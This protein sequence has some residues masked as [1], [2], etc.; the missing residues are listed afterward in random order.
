LIPTGSERVSRV[1]AAPEGS[2]V[3]L[4]VDS[5]GNERHQLFRYDGSDDGSGPP[6]QPLTDRPSVIHAAGGW[7]DGHRFVYASNERDQRYFDVYEL[8]VRSPGH[9][10][11]VYE[12][13]ALVHVGAVRRDRLIVVRSKSN[14]DADLLEVGGDRT[15]NLTP[16]VGEL[17]V[18]SVDLARDG[19]LAAANPDR[20]LTALVRYRAP[21]SS[22]VLREYP[23]DVEIVRVTADG[24]RAAVTVNREGWSELHVVD[25][26]ANEDRTIPLEIPG[27]I[28]S[29]E[30]T[31]DGT[32]LVFALSSTMLGQDLY[33]WVESTRR[34]EPLTRNPGPLPEVLPE[35]RLCSFTASDELTIPY[36]DL[37]PRREPPRGTVVIVHGGPEAQ[38]RPR[39]A[40]AYSFLRQEGWRI[41]LPNVRGSLGYGRTYVHLDDVRRRMDSVR[42][43]RDLVH[44]LAALGEVEPGRVG[45]LGGSYGGFMV[46]SAIATYPDLWGAAV[47]IVGISNFVTFLER[48]G[49]WRRKVREVEYGSLERDREFLESISPIGHTGAMRTPLLVIHGA[50]DPRV[51]VH[52]AEQ[53]VA[54]LSER[55]VPV[56][57]LRYDDEG[58]G[59]VRKENR[60]EA[61]ERAAAFFAKYL[62]PDSEA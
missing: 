28:E 23:G 39:F 43:L 55:K 27:V 46:L 35:A 24:Q 54:S 60:L 53:I 32:E 2:D 19:L 11:R 31:P 51:P 21:G 17:T 47:D 58:H 57:F 38:A 40:Q 50:N 13:D 59:L 26:H 22:E 36:W 48:T 9:A 10:V 5:G 25:L 49:V 45:V 6:S 20:E 42:D 15:R 14:L 7:R 18:F 56:E 30:W 37:R 12:E 29:L 44:H 4:S 61:Y 62:A 52:E 16:H 3:I 33:R 1:D 34:T 8:D 41:V